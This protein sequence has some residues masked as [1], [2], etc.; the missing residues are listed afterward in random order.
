MNRIRTWSNDPNQA[1][2][3]ILRKGNVKAATIKMT[4]QKLQ[5]SEEE[6]ISTLEDLTR[7]R[8]EWIGSS[9]SAEASVIRSIALSLLTS[10]EV[11][12]GNNRSKTDVEERE[13]VDEVKKH[14]FWWFKRYLANQVKESGYKFIINAWNKTKE[15]IDQ[16]LRNWDELVVTIPVCP[17]FS[18]GFEKLDNI[19]SSLAE[20][21]EYAQMHFW[22]IMKLLWILRKTSTNINLQLLIADGWMHLF[23]EAV[24]DDISSS[25]D[26]AKHIY[27]QELKKDWLGDIEMGLFSTYGITIPPRLLNDFKVDNSRQFDDFYRT[28]NKHEQNKID[29]FI[30]SLITRDKRMPQPLARQTILDYL[31]VADTMAKSSDIVISI[32]TVTRNELYCLSP[33]MK[34]DCMFIGFYDS[35]MNNK[36]YY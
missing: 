23:D 33:S 18:P 20:A 32:E 4:A 19:S 11:L 6:L 5:V 7:K 8:I 34:D 14:G 16:K 9:E 3:T 22:K 35:Y 17:L 10:L 13:T 25:I 12:K 24:A 29:S 30:E 21:S 26:R 15:K 31:N 27:K 1:I 36:P 28:M 2:E